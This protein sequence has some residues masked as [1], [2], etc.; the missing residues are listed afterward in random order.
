MS[1]A[2]FT[3][4]QEQALLDAAA[5]PDQTTTLGSQ[6]RSTRSAKDVLELL[7]RASYQRQ[8]SAGRSRFRYYRLTGGYRSN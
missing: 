6:S 2:K 5:E 3:A 4:D 1:E 8:R 7:D